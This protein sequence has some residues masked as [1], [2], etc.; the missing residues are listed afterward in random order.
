MTGSNLTDDEQELSTSTDAEELDIGEIG[1]RIGKVIAIT[2]TALALSGLTGEHLS[3][4]A[5]Y[6]EQQETIGPLMDPTRFARGNGFESVKRVRARV[7]VLKSVMELRDT[8]ADIDKEYL[9][10]ILMS[11]FR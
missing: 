2:Q 11:L 7:R 10:L 5:R 3:Q 8:R 9:K 4:M 6:V 1:K